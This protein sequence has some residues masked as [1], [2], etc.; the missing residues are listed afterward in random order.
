M[1]LIALPP[2]LA[3]EAD[4]ARS[5][6][7]LFRAAYH[8]YHYL[9]DLHR[10]DRH[11]FLAHRDG[12]VVGYATAR[13]VGTRA[14]L[15]NLLV[16]PSLRGS[17]LGRQLETARS[18]R[19]RELGLSLYTSCTCEDGGS[20]RLKWSIGMRPVA[21]RIGYRRGVAHAG[22]WGSSVVFTDETPEVGP[23]GEDRIHE[24]AER[25]RT[26]WIGA[27]PDP[28]PLRGIPGYVELLTGA[29][30]AARLHED[31]G[32]VYAGVD[33]DLETGTWL[34]SFQLRNA[35]YRAGLAERPVVLRAPAE[36]FVPVEPQ[37][38]A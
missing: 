21:L 8:E 3:P 13:V 23:V 30:G 2:G 1:D 9:D 12:R 26:R 37:E 18:G 5:V 14:V 33:L 10:T 35:A 4:T 11:R 20:Q 29:S 7:D 31:P 36:V 22:S 15:A 16:H 6:E 17:G 25:G 38:V 27:D 32:A 24:D 19:L 34:Y 28:A